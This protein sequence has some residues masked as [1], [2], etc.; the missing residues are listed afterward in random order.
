MYTVGVVGVPAKMLDRRDPEHWETLR[1][2]KLMRDEEFRRNL[3][4]EATYC[5]SIQFLGYTERE[6]KTELS[7]LKMEKR[8]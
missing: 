8:Q 6:A 1:C 4:G 5:L 2:R 3:I 7:L